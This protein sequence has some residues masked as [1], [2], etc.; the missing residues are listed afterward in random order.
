MITIFND[1]FDKKPK[2]VPVDYV[3]GGIRDC[4]IGDLI[5]RLRELIA[6]GEPKSVTDELKKKLP[7]ILF[8]GEFGSRE[9]KSQISHSGLVILDFD[10]VEDSVAKK[11]SLKQYPFVYT[12]F[13]SPS[14]NGVKAVVKIPPIIADH[15]AHYN[16]LQLVFPELD[17]T[18]I[19][20]AR[21]C[22]M[23]AD[24]EIWVNKDAI[25]FTDK[26][27]AKQ[28]AVTSGSTEMI[29]TGTNY[30]KINI[31][32]NKIRQSITG[33]KYSELL[34][35]AYLM[36]GYIASGQV[37]EH[38]AVRILEAEISKKD[39]ANLQTAQ[40]GIKDAIEAGKL[41]PL[42]EIEK[43][44]LTPTKSSGVLTVDGIWDSMKH[45]FK[46]GK[47]RGT[48]THF[49]EFDDRFTWKSGEI[50]LIV[51]R[52]NFGKTEFGMQL[53][54]MKSVFDGWKW[55]VFSPENYPADEFYDSLI[56]S[57]IGKTTDPYY[58]VLQ[59]SMEEYER[60]YK[61]VKEHFFYVYP[62][63]HSMEEVDANFLHLIKEKVIKGCFIDP[64][65][66]LEMDYGNRDDV[67][68]SKFLR[69]R[70]R[71]AIEYDLH[72]LVSTH[73]KSMSRDK[74]GRYPIPE[75]YDIA[76]G[77]MWANK[78]DNIIVIDRPN[79]VDNPSDTQVDIHVKKIK[80]QKLVGTPGVQTFH[81]S[82]KTNRYSINDYNPLEKIHP[83]LPERPYGSTRIKPPIE[84]VKD[85]TISQKEQEFAP[86][87]DDPDNW[88][89]LYGNNQI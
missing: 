83:K 73:P 24:S 36:G 42:Y 38:E 49:I 56:H 3:I 35:A 78:M 87:V 89:N 51:A 66:Q 45:T 7:S 84:P 80:K 40:K 76:G 26:V 12:A 1:V 69:D 47:K 29:A 41:K 25:E 43:E 2:Y 4:R 28:E 21:I 75:F 6:A 68:L 16:A 72:Y 52:P 63:V 65:N 71:F 54:L 85:I 17:G 48:T 23:S 33:Q 20:P 64:Y 19:N 86:N 13:I 30:A 61:F 55:A 70:K 50:T 46:H 53:M 34:K 59:M 15:R 77:A 14:G 37:E 39:I 67:F 22:F 81:F 62:E 5:S 44:I 82:R 10:K 74:N 88:Q 58:D 79:Y 31:A 8:S 57:Y 32:V 18:S 27:E 60:G 11:E 9:D